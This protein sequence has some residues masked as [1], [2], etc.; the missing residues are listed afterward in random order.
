MDSEG[1]AFS[2]FRYWQ[3]PL[4]VDVPD[5]VDVDTPPPARDSLSE[6]TDSDS[7]SRSSSSSDSSDTGS[8]KEALVNGVAGD[9]DTVE[10]G[11]IDGAND[12]NMER[13][14]QSTD[15]REA[16][17]SSDSSSVSSD[18]SPLATSTPPSSGQSTP[19]GTLVLVGG[20]LQGE[21]NMVI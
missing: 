17:E 15:S 16:L 19:P 11:P 8:S 1:D 7:G 6:N 13:K 20:M 3:S 12:G 4:P 9:G 10:E 18:D 14:Q 5:L 21:L 2:S